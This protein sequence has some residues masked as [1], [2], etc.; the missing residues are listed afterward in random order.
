MTHHQ[1]IAA[2][3]TDEVWL[4]FC[5]HGSSQNNE[6]LSSVNPHLIHEVL[7]HDVKVGVW[8]AVNDKR[9]IGPILYAETFVL[10]M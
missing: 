10:G 4:H 8:C 7:L 2:A 3:A 6:Y 9:I 5:G 1:A